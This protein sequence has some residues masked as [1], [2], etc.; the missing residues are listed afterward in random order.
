MPELALRRYL[1]ESEDDDILLK[2]LD[3]ARCSPSSRGTRASSEANLEGCP[4]WNLMTTEGCLS[5]ELQALVDAVCISELRQLNFSVTI[6]DAS[7]P[8]CPLI[9]CSSGFSTLTGYS[10]PEIVGR[11]CRFL[12]NGVPCEHVD[13]D[14]RMRCREFCRSTMRWEEYCGDCYLPDD[15]ES[16][17]V[18]IPK[19]QMVAVQTNARK[20]GTLFRNMFVLRQ[21]SLDD[22]MFVLGL[23]AELP[24]EISDGGSSEEESP[25]SSVSLRTAFQIF[26][27]NVAIVDTLLSRYFWY[28][29]PL[30]R[31]N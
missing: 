1:E 29:C 19:G 22:D 2:T 21:V 7:S 16:P 24:D 27:R 30:L 10:V 20:N 15:F 25:T 23:Q 12:L 11:N 26:E 3:V 9:A 5:R 8:E 14:V 13:D 28:T 31:Q 17:W 6:A 4:M 18:V